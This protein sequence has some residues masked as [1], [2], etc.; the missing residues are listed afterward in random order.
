M[1]SVQY[2]FVNFFLIVAECTV[3]G[4]FLSA[5][6]RAKMINTI[7]PPAVRCCFVSCQSRL[8]GMCVCDFVLT[9]RDG[10]NLK[11]FIESNAKS[12]GYV[13]IVILVLQVLRCCQGCRVYKD[14]MTGCCDDGLL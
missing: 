6:A 1:S 2:L 7:N 3:A 5:S 12:A 9:L 11:N 8:E 10:Q 4:F 14:V 13:V